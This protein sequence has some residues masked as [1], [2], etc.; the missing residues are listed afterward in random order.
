MLSLLP[1]FG[2]CINIPSELVRLLGLVSVLTPGNMPGGISYQIQQSTPLYML[3]QYL[4]A[5]RP[6]CRC[7]SGIRYGL[8]VFVLS[9]RPVALLAGAELAFP[10]VVMGAPCVRD[11]R[12]QSL[13]SIDHCDSA[14]MVLT[15]L[16]LVQAGRCFFAPRSDPTLRDFLS[17]HHIAEPNL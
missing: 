15:C 14:H 5:D 13:S 16:L 7:C 11:N 12:Y 9:R 10:A 6:C 8:C 2:G 17:Q 1:Y 4:G 3:A